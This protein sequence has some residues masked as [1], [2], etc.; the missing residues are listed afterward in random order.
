MKKKDFG[1]AIRRRRQELGL[2]MMD[3]QARTGILQPTQSSIEKGAHNP[4]SM[5]FERVLSYLGALRLTLPQFLDMTGLEIP[6]VGMD[7]LRRIGFTGGMS[8][9]GIPDYGPLSE[10]DKRRSPLSYAPP[11]HA[12]PYSDDM[13]RVGLD[14]GVYQAEGVSLPVGAS[15][16]LGPDDGRSRLVVLRLPKRQGYAIAERSQIERGPVVLRRPS[17]GR[18]LLLEDGGEVIG[19]VLMVE[20]VPESV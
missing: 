6:G 16:I 19:S 12:I 13:R 3:I 10:A 2:S 15:L 20:Y 1:E 9:D 8:D 14:A 17:D 11:P 5:S 4:L 18:P 7:D